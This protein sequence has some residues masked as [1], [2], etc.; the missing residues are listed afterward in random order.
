[1]TTPP[2]GS[3]SGSTP[4]SQPN[5][6]RPPDYSSST[7]R[8]IIVSQRHLSLF[9]HCPRRYQAEI[10]DRRSLPI[11]DQQRYAL[12]RGQQFH[13]LLQ[14]RALGITSQLHDPQLDRWL[15]RLQNSAT[16]QPHDD[17]SQYYLAEHTRTLTLPPFTLLVRYDALIADGDH[18]DIID[19]KTYARPKHPQKLADHW[20]T[21]LYRYVLAATSHY[22]PER[23]AMVYWF[24]ESTAGAAGKSDQ[25][26]DRHVA[27]SDRVTLPYSADQFQRDHHDIARLLDRL[28]IHLTPANPAPHLPF[29]TRLDLGQ[30]CDPTHCACIQLQLF[31]ERSTDLAAIEPSDIAQIPEV[32]P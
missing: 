1:M 30:P 17:P 21:R 18:A 11:S 12:Q 3:T 24:A 27:V 29:P 6:D 10:L 25:S 7:Q 32:V 19:W 16:L 13:H 2:L 23:I 31:G 26:R 28:A 9:E 14:Q 15:D 4:R 22:P 20:Q 8:L 5:P